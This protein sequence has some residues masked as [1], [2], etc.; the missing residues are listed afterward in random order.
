MTPDIVL[1]HVPGQLPGLLCCLQQHMHWLLVS[2][3]VWIVLDSW[4]LSHTLVL[5][6]GAS[7]CAGLPFPPPFSSY[8]VVWHA[9]KL[10]TVWRKRSAV[11]RVYIH[12][13]S[14]PQLIK[15]V[16][17]VETSYWFMFS[18]MQGKLDWNFTLFKKQSWDSCLHLSSKL[19]S[20]WLRFM[21]LKE[22]GLS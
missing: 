9:S 4:P 14:N 17:G 16:C 6:P 19:E 18:S 1:G 2:R 8:I 12:M 5:D 15:L 22:L 21:D 10:N 13:W 3:M 11:P 7:W 20:T